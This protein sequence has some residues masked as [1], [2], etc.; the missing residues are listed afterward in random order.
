MVNASFSDD[1]INVKCSFNSKIFNF[2]ALMDQMEKRFPDGGVSEEMYCWTNIL[3]PFYRGRAMLKFRKE[4]TDKFIHLH[5]NVVAVEHMEPSRQNFLDDNIIL[6]E[7]DCD[8]QEKYEHFQRQ[9]DA[10]SKSTDDQAASLTLTEQ[11]NFAKEMARWTADPCS[12][13]PELSNYMD[14]IAWW[15]GNY[16]KWPELAKVA[17]KY[18][19]IQPSS[20][21]AER[22]FSTCGNTV[23]AKRTRLNPKNVKMV[24]YCKENFPKV[25]MHFAEHNMKHTDN[26]LKFVNED[27]DEKALEQVEEALDPEEAA[28]E[29]DDEASEDESD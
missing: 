11:S 25:E 18:L 3:H 9:K 28:A 8:T 20:C 1:R 12:G 23:T 24:V 5:E 2:Q 6:D 15:R 16:Q 4:N 22:V 29:A 26:K 27:E 13:D 17:K 10:L 21:S 7:D 19:S 14:V